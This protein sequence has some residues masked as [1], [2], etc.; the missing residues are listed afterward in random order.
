MG[1]IGSIHMEYVEMLQM[2]ENNKYLNNR[3]R[4][5]NLLTKI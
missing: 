3:Q 5:G 4:V 2:N 1:K